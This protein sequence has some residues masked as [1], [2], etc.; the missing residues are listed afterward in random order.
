MC[1]FAAGIDLIITNLARTEMY[2]AVMQALQSA[3][4]TYTLP[5]V[6][7][8][9]QALPENLAAIRGSATGGHFE[10]ATTMRSQRSFSDD[11]RAAAA[12]NALLLA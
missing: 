12:Q 6:R 10:N 11:A 7:G 8:H 3:K 9:T 5:P 2:S 4:A 1:W